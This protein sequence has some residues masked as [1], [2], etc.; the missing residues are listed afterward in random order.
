MTAMGAFLPVP[1]ACDERQFRVDL[2]KNS[3]SI[4]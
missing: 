3:L 2:L 1:I 4:T